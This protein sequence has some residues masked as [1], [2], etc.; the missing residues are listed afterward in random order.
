[1]LI[2]FEMKSA[3]LQGLGTSNL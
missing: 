2:A 1:M 3:V